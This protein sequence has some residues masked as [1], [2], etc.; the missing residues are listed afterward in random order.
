MCADAVRE[1]RRAFACGSEIGKSRL[2]F[3]INLGGHRLH[4]TLYLVL[5][6]CCNVQQAFCKIVTLASQPSRLEDTPQTRSYITH[7]FPCIPNSTL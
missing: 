6:S 4:Q 3:R 1:F 2:A 7:K 5:S